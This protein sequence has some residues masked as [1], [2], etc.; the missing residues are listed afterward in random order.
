MEPEPGRKS[1]D[2]SPRTVDADQAILYGGSQSQPPEEE[3]IHR[4]GGRC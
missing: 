2:Q 4:G 3:V 1:A